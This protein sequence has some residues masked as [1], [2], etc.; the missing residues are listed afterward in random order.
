MERSR[1]ALSQKMSRNGT[2]LCYLC[3]CALNSTSRTLSRLPHVQAEHVVP[4]GVFRSEPT[5][6][7]P[8]T[9]ILDV[10]QPCDRN[11]KQQLDNAFIA[12]E[13]MLADPTGHWTSRDMGVF[14]PCAESMSYTNFTYGLPAFTD[15]V[16]LR[17]C[18][19]TWISGLHAALYCEYLPHIA[20]QVT[21]PP[22]PIFFHKRGDSAATQL[23]DFSFGKYA[24]LNWIKSAV[25]KGSWDG[26]RAWGGQ[27]KYTCIWRPKCEKKRYQCL[28]ALSTPK[29][30]LWS[31][32]TNQLPFPWF[33]VYACDSIPRHAS[34]FMLSEADLENADGNFDILL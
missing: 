14:R 5:G 32:S 30:R 7:S 4:K 12:I 22:V 23:G 17:E 25:A 31:A 1:R 8:W 24:V 16:G 21:S 27:L 29:T 9:V 6:S 3:G 11:N 10:H 18:V 33:G 20:H 34:T 19:R 2:G 28:W 15:K 13:R 26:V